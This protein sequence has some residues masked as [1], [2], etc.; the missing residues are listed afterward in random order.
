MVPYDSQLPE[1][2]D[3]VDPAHL[4]EQLAPLWLCYWY[5]S[6]MYNVEVILSV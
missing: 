2:A 4:G 6:Y 3:G 5:D 1:F